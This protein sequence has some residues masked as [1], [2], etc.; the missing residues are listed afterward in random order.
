MR[1]LLVALA[2]LFAV[3]IAVAAIRVGSSPGVVDL[4]SDRA[5]AEIEGMSGA[6]EQYR[7]THG[8]YP[9]TE[10]GLSSLVP[11]GLI[12]KVPVDPWSHPYK[13]RFPGS[14]NKGGFDLWT[15]GADGKPGGEDVDKDIGNWDDDA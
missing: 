11:A 14:R 12:R 1:R 7:E 5:R 8:R 2:I 15:Y 13:Y 6:I 3:L 4:K 10:E 9:T